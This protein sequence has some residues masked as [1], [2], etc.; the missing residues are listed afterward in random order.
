MR[1]DAA[2]NFITVRWTAPSSN[3]GIIIDSYNVY[4]KPDGEQYTIYHLH[5]DMYDLVYTLI[6]DEVDI[7]RTFHF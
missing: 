4:V 3:G 7:G 5:T 1:Y 2:K 6:V